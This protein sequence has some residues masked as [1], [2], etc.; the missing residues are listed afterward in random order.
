M[1]RRRM[2][3]RHYGRCRRLR[4]WPCGRRHGRGHRL[5]RSGMRSDGRMNWSSNGG[6]GRPDGHRGNGWPF[7]SGRGLFFAP[8]GGLGRR[9]R[10]GFHFGYG[11]RL[12]LSV[13]SRRLFRRLSSPLI[14]FALG[15]WSGRR[16]RV[17][18]PVVAAQLENHVVVE[19]AGMR[20]FVGDAE[21]GKTL[22]YFVSFHFQL[23]RQLVNSDLSHR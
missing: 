18:A 9:R 8:G 22:Q 16:S 2:R 13:R 19:R 10:S 20:L 6:D 1:W 15:F 17:L 23:S 4:L 7:G 11:L 12:R 3:W 21:F 5:A 14:R